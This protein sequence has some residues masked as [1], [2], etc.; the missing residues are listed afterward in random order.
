MKQLSVH[1]GRGYAWSA[2]KESGLHLEAV[3]AAYGRP[4]GPDCRDAKVIRSCERWSIA[5]LIATTL[6]PVS[7]TKP[8]G[9]VSAKDHTVQARS[10]GYSDGSPKWKIDKSRRKVSPR[11]VQASSRLIR[12]RLCSLGKDRCGGVL[13]HGKTPEG[14]HYRF[15][16]LL[17]HAASL[18]PR[19]TLKP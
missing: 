6:G 14:R 18:T 3:I 9:N 2:A 15:A 16:G 10:T 12:R 8:G 11:A 4:V 17:P 19:H 7:T 13:H 1:D 5:A